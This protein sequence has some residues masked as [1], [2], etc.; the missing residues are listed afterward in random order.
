MI[1]F[2]SGDMFSI[3]ANCLV[4]TVNC[5]GIMGTGVALAFKNRYPDMYEDYKKA[6]DL[7]QVRPGFL[8]VWE[9][10][11]TIIINFPTKRHWRN[12]SRYEDILIGLKALNSF[13][14][15]KPHLKV[16][17]PALGCGNGGLDWEIVSSMIKDELSSVNADIMVFEPKDSQ[18]LNITNQSRN[19]TNNL[20][21]KIK[22]IPKDYFPQNLNGFYSGNL[23]LL[24]K[25]RKITLSANFK[26]KKEQLAFRETLIEINR[27]HS[28]DTFST[29]YES[30]KTNALIKETL[31]LGFNL[32]VYLPLGINEANSLIDL[33]PKNRNLLILSLLPPN[34]EWREGSILGCYQTLISLEHRFLIT[35]E[36]PIWINKLVKLSNF[37][38]HSYFIKYENTINTLSEIDSEVNFNL[39]GRSKGTKTPNIDILFQENNI[40]DTKLYNNEFSLSFEELNNL[41][42]QLQ[43]YNIQNEIKYKI[44]ISKSDP[45]V[46]DVVKNI[47][48]EIK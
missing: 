7:G 5:V 25:D 44:N 11:E 8:H 1:T 12:K 17:L 40:K 42:I 39:I 33:L 31:A 4:N 20:K 9:N 35:E 10:A 47:L 6:C 46:I 32:I 16:S 28:L 22:P 21:E 45:F 29:V 48:K 14:T 36:H 41:I 2:T 43:K 15:D 13:L 27:K 37:A 19:K 26:T 23:S 3:N 30:S 38:K 34:Q 18:K 24:N